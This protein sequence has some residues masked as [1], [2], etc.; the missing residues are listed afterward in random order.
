MRSRRW[1]RKSLFAEP[2]AFAVAFAGD[3]VVAAAL[4]TPPNHLVLSSIDDLDAV[5]FLDTLRAVALGRFGQR[6]QIVISTCDRNLF[7]LM[8]QKF[9]P[10]QAVGTSFAA[11]SI[12]DRGNEGPEIRP[13]RLKPLDSTTRSA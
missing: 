1:A 13:Y 5:A 11:V 6:R 3:A 10:L 4:R 9:E 2:P 12:I 8:I 7:R